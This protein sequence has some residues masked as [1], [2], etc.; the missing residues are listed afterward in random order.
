MPPESATEGIIPGMQMCGCPHLSHLS[1]VTPPPSSLT[2]PSHLFGRLA[3]M[4]LKIS[5]NEAAAL[6]SH[7]ISGT[8][9]T[10]LLMIGGSLYVLVTVLPNMWVLKATGMGEGAGHAYPG[11]AIFCTR[12]T[13]GVLVCY[14][15]REDAVC[16]TALEEWIDRTIKPMYQ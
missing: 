5:A 7:V 8:L 2:F 11:G 12:G 15:D 13:T 16:A 1:A 3:A 6:C 10:G 14:G 4:H 9:P